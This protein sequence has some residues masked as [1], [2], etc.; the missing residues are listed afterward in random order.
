MHYSITTYV[1]NNI[2]FSEKEEEKPTDYYY[3]QTNPSALFAFNS[4]VNVKQSKS[5]LRLA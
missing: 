5:Q 3:S 4:I 1:N 2:L